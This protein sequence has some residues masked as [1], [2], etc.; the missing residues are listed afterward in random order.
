MQVSKQLFLQKLQII[1]QRF[2]SFHLQALEALEDSRVTQARHKPKAPWHGT[3]SASKNDTKA[4][5]CHLCRVAV[6]LVSCHCV[7][8]E[9]ACVARVTAAVGGF[10]KIGR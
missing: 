3:L 9:A 8:K 5:L 6:S 1:F 2:H 7:K 4:L 10:C